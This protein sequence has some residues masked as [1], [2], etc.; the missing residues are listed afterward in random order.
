MRTLWQRVLGLVPPIALALASGS[1][2]MTSRELIGALEKAGAPEV[3]TLKAFPV[4]L[5]EK[6]HDF[7]GAGAYLR[8]KVLNR[9]IHTLHY[10]AGPGGEIYRLKLGKPEIERMQSALKIEIKNSDAA[11]RY[12]QWLLEVTEGPALWLL[13]SVDDVPFQ[14]VPKGKDK[15][16]K[17]VE[18]AKKEIMRRISK[19]S[20]RS[21]DDGFIVTQEAV[22]RRDL[23][24][25]EVTVSSKGGT[26]VAKEKLVPELPVVYVLAH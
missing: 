26:V 8:V 24:R 5:E 2:A 18:Q 10:V 7:L 6:K 17:R 14:P 1:P 16:A 3:R 20:A 21:Q 13:S 22:Q 23:V 25:F 15:L 4:E 19:P 9:H 12:V 11:L